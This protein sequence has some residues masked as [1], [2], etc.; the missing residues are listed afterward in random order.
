[1][2]LQPSAV[3]AEPTPDFRILVVG[4]VVLDEY[5]SLPAVGSRQLLQKCQV[6]GGV[7]DRV[8]PVM[9]ASSPEFDGAQNL[10]VLAFAGDGNFGRMAH[11]A[12]GGMQGRVLTKTGFVGKDQCPVLRVGF[13]LICG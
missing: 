4:G 3:G 2:N 5:G 8:L 11:P 10:N 9:E 1:M 13:F 12:P 7:E 6:A